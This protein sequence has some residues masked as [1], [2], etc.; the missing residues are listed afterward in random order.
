MG[1]HVEMYYR[2]T[3]SN[4]YGQRLYAVVPRNKI[5]KKTAINVK[6]H[7]EVRSINNVLHKLIRDDVHTITTAYNNIILTTN[8]RQSTAQ[9]RDC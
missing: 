3:D 7:H 6:H 8:A 2:Q 4:K 1:K 9:T 5:E